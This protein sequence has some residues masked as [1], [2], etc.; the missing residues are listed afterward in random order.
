MRD[1][2]AVLQQMDAS[3]TP[4]TRASVD[5]CEVVIERSAG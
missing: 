2:A 4:G 1:S 5:Q 3:D